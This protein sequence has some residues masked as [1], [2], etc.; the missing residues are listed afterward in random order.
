MVRKALVVGAVHT[1]LYIE[2]FF[3]GTKRFHD[4]A[5]RRSSMLVDCFGGIL[6][7]GYLGHPR[8]PSEVEGDFD[9]VAYEGGTDAEVPVEAREGFSLGGRLPK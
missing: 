8:F 3:P 9:V 5:N 1:N 6:P 2:D 7:F 4:E